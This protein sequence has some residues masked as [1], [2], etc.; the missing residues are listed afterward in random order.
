LSISGARDLTVDLQQQ[1]LTV[2]SAGT[3]TV[4]TTGISSG[5]GAVKFQN[6]SITYTANPGNNFAWLTEQGKLTLDGITLKTT[7]F[8]SALNAQGQYAEL[9]VNN[10][11]VTG[12]YY[13]F[14]SNA[15]KT[16]GVLDYGQDAKITL[17]NSKFMSPETGLMNNV[18]ATFTISG[19][20]FQGNHQGALFR[21][22]TYTL[23]GTN[24]FLLKPTLSTSDS[25]CKNNADWTDGNR[26][27]YAALTIGNR[28][29]TGYP[30]A[31]SV[32]FGT[33]T[34][35]ATTVKMATVGADTTSYASYFPGVYVAANST[36]GQGVTISGLSHLY[37]D[38]S[39]SPTN[40]DN[41]DIV[42]Y[43]P[44]GG[45]SNIT[46]D[47]TTVTSSTSTTLS[48]KTTSN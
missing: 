47:G 46:V 6:G 17:T 23:S 48:T 25:E 31:T 32:T 24:T 30:Y 43:I 20:T 15:R 19:C 40:N 22:G 12:M 26:A 14:S 44:D 33:G 18:P 38:S 2:T 29:N 7:G 11:F 27:A 39:V 34:S 3:S 16:N 4:H 45:S 21:A 35:D 9:V 28:N 5:Y 36:S 1:E 37:K 10:S 8:G 13:S 41:K 42:Y